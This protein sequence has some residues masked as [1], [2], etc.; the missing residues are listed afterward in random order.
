MCIGVIGV[1]VIGI[2]VGVCLGVIGVC[3][4]MLGV[5]GVCRCV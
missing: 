1:Y 2:C 5:I 3:R 4:C